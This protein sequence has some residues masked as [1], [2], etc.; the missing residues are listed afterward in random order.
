MG[1]IY[2]ITS[3]SGKSYVG[4][5]VNW[6]E[7]RFKRH[8]T[9]NGGCRAIQNAILKYGWD[10]CH[11]TWFECDDADLDLYERHYI[12][13]FGTMYPTGYNL[14]HGGTGGRLSDIS[15]AKISQTLKGRCLSDETRRKMSLSRIGRNH[16][17]SHSLAISEAK[18]KHSDEHIAACLTKYKNVKT[19][20]AKLGV[21]AASIYYRIKKSKQLQNAWKRSPCSTLSATPAGRPWLSTPRIPA[22]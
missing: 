1:F 14:K 15:L 22:D 13:V 7:D 5:T 17:A 19:V 21:T 8:R 18:K 2:I 12:A 9:N 11:K 10:A 6:I 16:T 3:P 20:A 4:Q